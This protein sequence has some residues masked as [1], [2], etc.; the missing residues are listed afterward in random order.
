M[1]ELPSFYK[2]A[3]DC[4]I[5]ELR[6]LMTEPVRKV[7]LGDGL[8]A[9]YYPQVRIMV[10]GDWLDTIEPSAHPSNYT[11]EHLRQEAIDT[12]RRLSQPEPDAD[13]ARYRKCL[14]ELEAQQAE[15]SDAR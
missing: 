2:R 8:Y 6:E 14:A 13:R 10:G 11:I 3:T 12:M 1:F 4:T 5:D 15:V 7:S 9:I